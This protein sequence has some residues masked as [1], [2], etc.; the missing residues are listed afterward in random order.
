M[1]RV[2]YSA[3]FDRISHFVVCMK[4]VLVLYS[5]IGV[6]ER[7]EG[8]FTSMEGE[9]RLRNARKETW[10]MIDYILMLILWEK[11]QGDRFVSLLN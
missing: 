3:N 8:R 7:C 2:I 4:R 10:L 9:L 11:D 5:V 1:D 6:C